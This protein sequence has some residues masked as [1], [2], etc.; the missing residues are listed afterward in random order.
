MFGE[1]G[2]LHVDM[3]AT[4]TVALVFG[5]IASAAD[6]NSAGSTASTSVYTL[7]VVLSI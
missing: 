7:F 4:T 5:A 3:L 1:D 2:K 6:C